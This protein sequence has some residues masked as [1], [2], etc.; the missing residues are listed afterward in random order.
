MTF[1]DLEKQVAGYYDRA[2]NAVDEAARE[3]SIVDTTD[4]DYDHEARKGVVTLEV[5]VMALHLSTTKICLRHIPAPVEYA[6]SWAV[7]KLKSYFQDWTIET[8]GGLLRLGERAAGFVA[9]FTAF[10]QQAGKNGNT[11]SAIRTTFDHL[12]Y[13]LVKSRLRGAAPGQRVRAKV[14]SR[15]RTKRQK[16]GAL[17]VT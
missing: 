6:T 11:A 16:R 10:A 9:A 17:N 1:A 7:T 12:R 3:V 13:D 5:A 15:H 2:F 8:L 14:H 4:A